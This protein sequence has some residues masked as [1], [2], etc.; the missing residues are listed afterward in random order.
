VTTNSILTGDDRALLAHHGAALLQAKDRYSSQR[1]ALEAHCEFGDIA[2][3]PQLARAA[4]RGCL[5]KDEERRGTPGRYVLEN[6]R[7]LQ[8]DLVVRSRPA[9]R[10][11]GR[12]GSKPQL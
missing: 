3:A 6:A 2:R 1:A 12:T 9:A 5:G 11:P 8:H 10:D 4:W 7:I